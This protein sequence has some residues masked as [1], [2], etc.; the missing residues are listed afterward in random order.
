MWASELG[1]HGFGSKFPGWVMPGRAFENKIPFHFQHV[2]AQCDFFQQLVLSRAVAA[3][4]T[5]QLISILAKATRSSV[6]V[7]H[8]TVEINTQ[9]TT[10]KC[11][12]GGGGACES[13][14]FVLNSSFTLGFDWGLRFLPRCKM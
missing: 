12:V 4:K 6:F 5:C 13:F 3:A 8:L 11:A 10:Y 1:D 7:S 9:N 14:G 2:E